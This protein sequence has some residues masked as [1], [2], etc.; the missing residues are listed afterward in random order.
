M[1]RHLLALAVT[2]VVLG[3]SGCASQPPASMAGGGEPATV[4]CHMTFAITGWAA[5]VKHASGSGLVT[6]ADGSSSHVVITARGGGL[7]VGKYHIDNGHGQFTDVHS[8]AETYGEY[9]QGAVH[10]GVVHSGHAQV[11]SKGT[12]SL[13]LSGTGQGAGLGVSVG[14]FDI[15]PVK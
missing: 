5:L 4:D 11:L 12:V 8:I 15:E 9:I 6:C 13:A 3:L 10:A 7:T 2:S 1:K 14:V